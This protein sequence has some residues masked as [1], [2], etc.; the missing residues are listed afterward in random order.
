MIRFT[1]V[2]VGSFTC[3]GVYAALLSSLLRIKKLT[4]LSSFSVEF[5]YVESSVFGFFEGC[6]FFGA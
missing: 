1:K 4:R 6:R 5:V 3:I 2:I